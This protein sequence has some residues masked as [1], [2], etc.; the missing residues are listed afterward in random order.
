MNAQQRDQHDELR[1]L[2]AHYQIL[3]VL[4]LQQ[5]EHLVDQVL[6]A[7]RD[8]EEVDAKILVVLELQR[9]LAAEV[10]RTEGVA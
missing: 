1:D 8:I 4:Y 10:E 5:R 2:L 9:D 7:S 3:R 6:R